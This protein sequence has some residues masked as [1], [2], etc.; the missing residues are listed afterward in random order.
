MRGGD[1]GG[2]ESDHSRAPGRGIQVRRSAEILPQVWAPI[3]N[4]GAV[5]KG[6]LTRPEQNAQQAFRSPDTEGSSM[7][8]VPLATI[9]LEVGTPCYVYSSAGIREQYPRLRDAL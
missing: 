4:R 9:A 2:N 8:G 7:E 1:Q 6:I 5:G 3:D